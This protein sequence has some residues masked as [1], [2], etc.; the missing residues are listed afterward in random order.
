MATMTAA[1]QAE[2]QTKTPAK[3]RTLLRKCACGG[4]KQTDDDQRKS[5]L[6]QR[7]AQSQIDDEH[8]PAVVEQALRSGGEALP[9]EVREHFESSFGHSFSQVRI[10]TD[11]L[12]ARSARAVGA[13]AFT[14][15]SDIVFNSSEFQPNSP[16]GRHLIAHELTHVVQ[17]SAMPANG[18]ALK[19][20]R[21]DSG[22]ERE[23]DR[24]ADRV[25]N[26]LPPVFSTKRGQTNALPRTSVGGISAAPAAIQR[27]GECAG[28]VGSNCNGT[29]CT[30]ATG[31]RGMCQW[32]GITYGCNCRDQSGDESGVAR[33]RELLPAWLFALLSAAAIAAIAACFISGVCEAGAIVAAAGAATAA[34]VIGI[35][36][37]A[38][39]TV[40]EDGGA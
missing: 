35:L 3:G 11:G 6:L 22:F 1:P 24:I 23:A 19:I 14:V 21:T 7:K 34:L 17:Q 9:D 20:G 28:K 40:T 26:S 38:G 13:R 10:H 27:V 18:G 37:A 33:V 12:A 15:G 16:S 36:R 31:R 25:S 2:R 5:L 4:S 8:A 32:G 39:V 30:T 29:R